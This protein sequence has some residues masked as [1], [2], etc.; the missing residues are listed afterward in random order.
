MCYLFTLIPLHLILIINEFYN[1]L[2]KVS[3]KYGNNSIIT[4]ES[5]KNTWTGLTFVFFCSL[6]VIW[7]SCAFNCFQSMMPMTILLNSNQ[8]STFWI[9]RY[10]I[11]IGVYR[12]EIITTET[13]K[14]HNIELVYQTLYIST[15][16]KK[17][18]K[19]HT[20]FKL[21]RVPAFFFFCDSQTLFFQVQH[22]VDDCISE[23]YF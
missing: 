12:S 4:G 20:Y 11:I 16:T 18:F 9:W 19:I 22:P 6:C 5:R 1:V 3:Q 10:L 13:F 21:Y 8:N 7:L 14:A 15:V 23:V 2:Y 17:S